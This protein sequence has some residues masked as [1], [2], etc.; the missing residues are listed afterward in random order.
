VKY[1]GFKA[2]LSR[3][4]FLCDCSYHDKTAHLPNASTLELTCSS[5]DTRQLTCISIH[6]TQT[7]GQALCPIT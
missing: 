4:I 5:S 3:V 2:G 1:R 6:Q 7:M